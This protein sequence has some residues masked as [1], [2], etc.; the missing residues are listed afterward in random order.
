[1]KKLALPG[2]AALAALL[3]SALAAATETA[4]PDYS[5]FAKKLTKAEQILHALDRLT[6]GPRP[7]DVAVLEKMGLKKWLDQQLH[8]ERLPENPLL[9]AKL[10]PLDSL[11]M[12][13][14][15]AV[16]NYPPR[17]LIRRV[18]RGLEN[19]PENP[20]ARAAIERMADRLKIAKEDDD[21]APLESPKPIADLLT[22][23]QLRTLRNGTA[24]QKR[25]ILSAIPSD[26]LDDIVLALPQPL[27]QQLMNV[28]DES[29]RRK[30]ML[31][32]RPE[33]IVPTDL[34][35]AKLYRAIYSTHQLEEQMVDFWF[36]HFNVYL[37]KGA[38]RV[39]V[40]AYERDAIRP[41][42]FGKFRDLLEAIAT[43][44]AMLFYLDNWQSVA[45]DIA[46]SRRFAKKPSRGLN[47]NYARE[48][49][50][51]HTLGVDGGY[52]QQDIIEVARCFTG[53][54]IQQPNLGGGFFYSDIIHDQ[55]EKTL[56]GVTIPARG[57]KAD[58]ERVLDILARHASTA[59]F[60]SRKLAQ[61]FVADDPPPALI[62][63]MAKT[64][65]DTDGDIR[66]V[67]TTI[68]D[69]PEF[70]SQGAYRA[71]VKTPFELMVSAVR[72]TA[73]EVDWAMP[74]ANQIA[75]L[76]QP[77]YRK[78]EPTG[79][80]SA[81]AEW[82]NSAALL[83]RM[84]FA[85]ALFGNRVDGVKLDASRFSADPAE[86]ARAVLFHDASPQA[87][88]SIEKALSREAGAAPASVSVTGLVLG[89]PEFQRR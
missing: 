54:T 3:F 52:T 41:H 40:T 8:P 39:L 18:A 74:L 4:N 77:L 33:Q 21:D 51:L 68:I 29:I 9:H 73:A 53:W 19:P 55:G 25:A 70:F 30:L 24:D 14:A 28:A 76:G 62:E 83:G 23:E 12:T 69:S 36:N 82:V 17:Q 56:L 1:M 45:P 65:R 66:A 58:A 87:L 81:N 15:E 78:L 2:V 72:A 64:F 86:A 48:L 26:Q 35:Q 38:D 5:P 50:E 75:Q 59:H 84:N 10:A 20:L 67:L 16:A 89:S 79:Y 11:E 6:F 63:R 31:S 61:K 22:Q 47:E 43:S 71:K 32:I 88:A 34:T 42:V 57:G 49:M 27:R 80:S 13:S 7:G 85:I 44:P 46:P 37:D 60:I